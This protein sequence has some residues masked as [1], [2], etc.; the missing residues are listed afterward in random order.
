MR[1]VCSQCVGFFRI[2]FW[3]FCREKWG[4]SLFSVYHV[5]VGADIIRLV[6]GGGG[7][8]FLFMKRFGR[9]PSPLPAARCFCIVGG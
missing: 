4:Q 7:R 3:I 8:E 6:R 5:F 9:G 2:F 1:G